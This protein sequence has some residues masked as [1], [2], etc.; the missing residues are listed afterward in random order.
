MSKKSDIFSVAFYY[1]P[2]IYKCPAVSHTQVAHCSDYWWLS[3]VLFNEQS[4][5]ELRSR[6]I[7]CYNAL[8]FGRFP[9]NGVILYIQG[10]ERGWCYCGDGGKHKNLQREPKLTNWKA[11]SLI[12]WRSVEH[13]WVKCVCVCVSMPLTLR[14]QTLSLVLPGI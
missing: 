13:V 6:D 9:T 10:R 2:S 4:S 3:R 5:S 12:S 1:L 7:V 11:H 14:H 8:L